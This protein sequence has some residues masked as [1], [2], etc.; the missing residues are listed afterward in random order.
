VPDAPDPILVGGEH[1]DRSFTHVAPDRDREAAQATRQHEEAH[2]RGGHLG[3]LAVPHL[4]P[5][6]EDKAPA[7]PPA[8]AHV[9]GSR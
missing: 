8:V 7:S 4:C 1:A 5:F 9:E 2:R 6:C 3:D